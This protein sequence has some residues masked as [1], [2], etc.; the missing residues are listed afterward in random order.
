MF[1]GFFIGIPQFELALWKSRRAP[2][3]LR[4]L[5][6]LETLHLCAAKTNRL[7]TFYT[8]KVPICILI[9][10]VRVISVVNNRMLTSKAKTVI[11]FVHISRKRIISVINSKF[12]TVF[13]DVTLTGYSQTL[14]TCI[15]WFGSTLEVWEPQVWTEL[16]VCVLWQSLSLLRYV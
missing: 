1:H 2:Y 16:S 9:Y 5:H 10:N 14:Y 11:A 3:F 15:R 13:E 4:V 6:H 7:Y 12:Y 8:F